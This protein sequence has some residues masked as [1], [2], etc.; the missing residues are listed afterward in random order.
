MRCPAIPPARAPLLRPRLLD[1]ATRSVNPFNPYP[2]SL[3]AWSAVESELSS[4]VIVTLCICPRRYNYHLHKTVTVPFDADGGGAIA[5]GGP[6]TAKSVGAMANGG[7]GAVAAGAEGLEKTGLEA[8]SRA[9]RSGTP[10]D[11]EYDHRKEREEEVAKKV[12]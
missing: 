11:Y 4:I 1:P 10:L 12:E 2:S 8:K 7:G 9:S 6:A 3:S 5:D